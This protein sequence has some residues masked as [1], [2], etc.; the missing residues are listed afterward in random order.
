MI[1]YNDERYFLTLVF[2]LQLTV[3]SHFLDASLVYGSSK[4]VAVSLRA[5]IG[6]RLNVDIRSNREWLPSA[7]NKSG[8]CDLDQ[9]EQVCY[10]AGK[11]SM[12]YFNCRC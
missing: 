1:T 6:G 5:G 10:A 7:T 9:E 11:Y 12:V 2:F 8:A 3:V 4:D